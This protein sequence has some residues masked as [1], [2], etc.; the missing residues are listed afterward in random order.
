MQRKISAVLSDLDGL[1]QDTDRTVL[2]CFSQTCASFGLSDMDHLFYQCFNLRRADSRLV[3]E[4]RLPHLL[5][6]DFDQSTEKP[7][8][9]V[10]DSGA[11]FDTILAKDLNY[12]KC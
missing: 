10:A 11:Q 7:L 6:L 4:R 9:M 5:D 12:L 3:L 8:R 2:D 1:L